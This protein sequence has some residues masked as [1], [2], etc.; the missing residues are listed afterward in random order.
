M[1]EHKQTPVAPHPAR[2]RKDRHA[3]EQLP[4]GPR[5]HGDAWETAEENEPEEPS[6]DDEAPPT[7]PKAPPKTRKR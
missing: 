3:D 4:V 6:F 5:Y 1:T 2:P 7:P